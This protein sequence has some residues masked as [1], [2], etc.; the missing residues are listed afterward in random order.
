M[1]DG[2][3]LRVNRVTRECGGVN[4]LL[5]SARCHAIKVDTE[6][7]IIV[8][9]FAS[10]KSGR[11]E[12]RRK[13]PAEF[14]VYSFGEMESDGAYDTFKPCTRLVSFP[15]RGS[16]KHARDEAKRYDRVLG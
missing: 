5:C 6:K 15:A 3:E 10:Y 16:L 14:A 2:Y 13:F 8:V 11:G 4:V 7:K 12:L 1:S 9:H